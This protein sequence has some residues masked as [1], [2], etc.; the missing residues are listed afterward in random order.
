MPSV[1]DRVSL[2]TRPQY[3]VACSAEKQGDFSYLSLLSHTVNSR[4][5]GRDLGMRLWSSSAT[6]GVTASSTVFML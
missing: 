6:S 5:L 3:S 4:K 2:I 1:H